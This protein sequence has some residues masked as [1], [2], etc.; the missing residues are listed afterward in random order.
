MSFDPPKLDLGIMQ[1]GVPKTGT[2][3]I[4][5]N[6]TEAIQIKKAV[7]S[8]GCGGAKFRNGLPGSLVYRSYADIPANTLCLSAIILSKALPPVA[9]IVACSR[10]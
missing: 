3:K 1:P 2:V 6:G 7:A 10:A 9:G 4:T 8:C 5:N